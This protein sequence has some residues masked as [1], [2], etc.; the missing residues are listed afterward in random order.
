M[1]KNKTEL[2]KVHSEYAK[3]LNRLRKVC[4]YLQEAIL[5]RNNL[6]NKQNNFIKMLLAEGRTTK[7]EL[8]HYITRKNK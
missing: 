1:F 7:E 5:L 4:I 2:Q 8:S 3:D 6:I